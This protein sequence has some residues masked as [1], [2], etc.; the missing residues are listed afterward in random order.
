MKKIKQ[1]AMMIQD[2]IYGQGKLMGDTV[3][4]Y[5]VLKVKMLARGDAS[6]FHY[7]D[8]RPFH[9][10]SFVYKRKVCSRSS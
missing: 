4:L 8:L 9:I 10:E 6:R 3:A 5:R 2:A 7:P 1:I